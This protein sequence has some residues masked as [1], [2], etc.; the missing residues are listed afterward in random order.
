[1]INPYHLPQYIIKDTIW[2]IKNSDKNI[3]LTFDDGPNPAT[4]PYIL[5][6]LDKNSIKATFF[7][8]GKN[9]DH[10][11]TL[12]DEIIKRGHAVGNHTYSHLKGWR[13][14][15]QEYINDINLAA[16]YI[17]GNIF[18]PPYGQMKRSQIKLLRDQYKIYFWS[19]LSW[20]FN[21]SLSAKTCVNRV[22]PKTRSGDIIV[23]HDSSK[24][25]ERMQSAL[26]IAINKLQNKGF[27]FCLI[28]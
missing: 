22:V 10:R 4:T 6:I 27:N 26:P 7:C 12:F 20:D 21:E 8:I 23:F 3:F 11:P 18:R 16:Q 9:V 5:D 17:P 24:A 2:R 13:S 14:S 19:V 25:F 28:E 1:M 15:D